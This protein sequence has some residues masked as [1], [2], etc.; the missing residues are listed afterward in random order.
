MTP[1]SQSTPVRNIW[2]NR[3]IIHSRMWIHRWI[4]RSQKYWSRII[5]SAR[6]SD[7]DKR[8]TTR[9]IKSMTMASKCC[10]LR[11]IIHFKRMTY[12]C[13]KGSAKGTK[14]YI[15]HKR[16]MI[17]VIEFS[18]LIGVRH[19]MKMVLINGKSWRRP[20]HHLM[21]SMI[22]LANK[23]SRVIKQEIKCVELLT[24]CRIQCKRRH[25]VA[26]KASAYLTM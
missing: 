3:S 19:R 6:K 1:I 5:S 25:G 23:F 8:M 20:W 22:A 18:R 7:K 26:G 10:N 13:N 21:A 14:N 15:C 4:R 24:L 12:K 9:S 2:I 17:K 11:I 16:Y